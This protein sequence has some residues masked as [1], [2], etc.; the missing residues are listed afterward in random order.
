MPSASFSSP[1]AGAQLNA[2]AGQYRRTPEKSDPIR[3]ALTDTGTVGSG[4]KELRTKE[5]HENGAYRLRRARHKGSS[6]KRS[7]ATLRARAPLSRARA[8]VAG[9]HQAK[10]R[11]I[12]RSREG[13]SP[14]P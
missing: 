11:E 1:V 7:H 8:A 10:E 5:G 4:R 12:G 2:H 14:S 9:G 3:F 6:R 13:P